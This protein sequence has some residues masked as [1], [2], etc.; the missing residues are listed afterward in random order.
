MKHRSLKALSL[1]LTLAMLLGLMPAA[2]AA[3]PAGESQSVTLIVELEAEGVLADPDRGPEAVVRDQQTILAEIRDRID[4]DVVPGYSYTHVLN[5][6]SLEADPGDAAAIRALEGVKAVRVSGAVAPPAADAGALSDS[7]DGTLRNI[8]GADNTTVE[9]SS[10]MTQVDRLHAQGIRGQGMVVA[11]VDSEFDLGSPFLTADLENPSQARYKTAAELQTVMDTA[12][13]NAGTEAARA[14]KNTKVPFAW[15]YDGGGADTYS[16]DPDDTHGSH[17]AGI[18]AG[19]GGALP[20]EQDGTDSFDGAAPEAQ[21]LLMACPSLRDVSLLAA[22][23]DA[24]KLGADAI[25]MSWGSDYM[26][27]T[28]FSDVMRNAAAA[29]ILLYNASGNS[30]RGFYETGAFPDMPDYGSIGTPG[31]SARETMSVASADNTAYWADYSLLTVG[32]HE[33]R[34][35]DQN[36]ELPFATVSGAALVYCGLDNPEG[37]ELTGKIAVFDRG[38]MTFYDRIQGIAIPGGAAGALFILNEEDNYLQLEIAAQSVAGLPTAIVGRDDGPFLKTGGTV[39]VDGAVIWEYLTRDPAL[40][41]FTAWGVFR[42]LT[43]A[44]DITAPG[45]DV[46]SSVPKVYDNTGYDTMLG[47]S[48]ASPHMTGAALLIKQ[49][50]LSNEP[51]FGEMSPTEQAAEIH[52][53]AMST[54]RVMENPDTGLPYSPRRQGAGLLQA[55]SAVKTP[56]VLEGVDDSDR[57]RAKISLRE[58]G[59]SFEVSFL[60]RNLTDTAVTYDSLDMVIFTDGVGNDGDG[61]EP[62]L[63]VDGAL[64]LTFTA[65]LPESVTVPAGGEAEISIPVTLDS[66]ETADLAEVFVNGFY[67][68][69]FVFLEDTG[70]PAGHPALSIPFMGF[71]GDWD[72]APVLDDTVWGEPVLGYTRLTSFLGDWPDEDSDAFGVF[73]T[74]EDALGCNRVLYYDGFANYLVGEEEDAEYDAERFGGISPNGDGLYDSLLVD[75][76]P[77]RQADQV[78][79]TLLDGQ[80]KPVSFDGQEAEPVWLSWTSNDAPY[81]EMEEAFPIFRYV[82]NLFSLALYSE[83]TG[84]LQAVP[85]EEGDYTLRVEARRTEESPRTETLDMPFYVDVTA[86]EITEAAIRREGDRTCIDVTA[87]DN[88]YISAIELYTVAGEPVQIYPVPGLNRVSCSFDITDCDVDPNELVISVDDYAL[89]SVEEKLPTCTVI[90]DAAGGKSPRTSARTDVYG[91]LEELPEP[92]REGYAFDGWY[93]LEGEAVTAGTV[94]TT[95]TALVARWEAC[96]FKDVLPGN[97]Y[98]EA[99]ND[100]YDKGYVNGTGGGKFTPGGTMD[101]AMFA[102]VLH[103]MAGTPEALGENVFPDVEEGKWYTDAVVWAAGEGIIEGYSDGT[104]G[105]KDP[106]TRE[107]IVALLWRLSEK[108]AGSEEVLAAFTDSERISDYA[109]DAFAWAVEAGIIS[110]KGHGI[111]D[112]RGNATRAEAAR[113]IMNYDNPE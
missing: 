85:L 37:L 33:I 2:L 29:G 89:N 75:L 22:L 100:C 73:D 40:S 11:I 62:W 66:R 39:T 96:V 111:L 48:M 8:G 93:T 90:F 43:L 92:T 35:K 10:K 107:Q 70:N 28:V 59:D 3:G 82:M 32:G 79:F 67:V 113:I 52:M 53:R 27:R 18:A 42:D 86:P 21:L 71:R 105:T 45:G 55:D 19:K 91:V 15:S 94:F 109:R 25:N 41:D 9:N 95:D 69:G 7:A 63:V 26:E 49:Y 50:L 101:R 58:I 30:G 36:S 78:T 74:T 68:D 108:P 4:P 24:V 97:W 31:S 102:T 38:D 83:E 1:I 5:A 81:Y 99:V 64:A 14:W 98:Y 103:R 106:V 17:V 12:G 88:R 60:A 44:P 80:G 23:D 20:A 87:T 84:G 51:G 77:L 65:S 16:D 72:A 104:F 61:E 54:A 56:V 34:F 110:G 46:Y 6:F 57:G 13:L 47:T 76:I 112:P